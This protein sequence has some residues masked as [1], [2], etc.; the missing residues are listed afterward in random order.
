MTTRFH[1]MV[2]YGESKE[3]PPESGV[4]VDK[5]TEF[6]YYGDVIRASRS[7]NDGQHLNDNISLSNSISILAD[8]YAY[9]N[10]AKIK[11]VM[12]QGVPWIVTSVEVRA[13]RLIL[14]VGSV[15]N[16]PTA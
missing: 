10:Y 1:G 16:G 3:D 5:I 15:Y 4:W 12:V 8:Q 13:P 2:G 14:T 6:P 11:Y 9:L 7:L